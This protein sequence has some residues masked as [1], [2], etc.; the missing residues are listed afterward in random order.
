MEDTPLSPVLLR[1]PLVD[2]A[3]GLVTRPWQQWFI[4]SWYRQ[5]GANAPPNNELGEGVGTL[6][7]QLAQT[8]ADLAVAQAA[9]EATQAALETTQG[10]LDTAEATIVTLQAELD[11]TQA[12]LAALLPNGTARAVAR[13]QAD[14]SGVESAVG[15]VIDDTGQLGV[16]AA[17]PAAPL[18]V[19]GA[20]RVDEALVA[21][22]LGTDPGTTPAD[23]VQLWVDNQAGFAGLSALFLR[24]GEGSMVVFGPQVGLG[25]L[26]AGTLGSGAS[27]RRLNVLGQQLFTAASTVQERPV[28]LLNATLTVATDATRTSRLGLFTY[29]SVAAR[30]N[31]RLEADGTAARVSFFG[32]AAVIRQTGGVATAAAAYGVNE[33]GMLQRAYNAL[34]AYGLLT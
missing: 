6:E 23:T 32:V 34:R 12:E 18:H 17:T 7:E 5:G 19:V 16:G 13:Y 15:V 22:G 8:Q 25:T 30:E 1:S 29:D 20:M 21:L 11:A 10:D 14:G 9:L 26:C 28:A 24:M 2:R 27:F 31:L 33:Q 4:A 3:T